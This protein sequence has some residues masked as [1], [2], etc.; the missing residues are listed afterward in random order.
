MQSHIRVAV[1]ML[2]GVAAFL[3]SPTPP[4]EADTVCFTPCTLFGSSVPTT[5]DAGPDSPVKV[6]TKFH[7]DTYGF[8]TGVRFYKSAAN[9]GTHVGQLWAYMDAGH[10]YLLDSV[11]FTGETASGWQTAQF[12]KPIA[13]KPNM[14]YLVSYTAPTGHFAFDNHYYDSVPT[15][16]PIQVESPGGLYT[17]TGGTPL[18]DPPIGPS[19][20]ANYYVDITFETHQNETSLFSMTTATPA[21]PSVVDNHYTQLGTRFIPDINTTVKGVRFYGTTQYPKPYWIYLWKSDGTLLASASDND[22]GNAYTGW[23]QLYFSTPIAVDAGTEYVVS[24]YQP[25]SVNGEYARTTNVFTA[26]LTFGQFHTPTNAGVFE[27]SAGGAP[28]V[29]PSTQTTSNFWVDPVFSLS[30]SATVGGVVDPSLTFTVGNRGT[31]CNGESNFSASAGGS[32]AVA[33]GTLGL[34]ANVSGA[35]ALSV[36]TNAAGGFSV[37]IRGVQSSQNMRSATHNWADVAGVYPAG[38]ALGAGE[39][40]GYTFF[41]STASSSV[42]NPSAANFIALDATNRAV[43]GSATS[44]TGSGCVSFDAQSTTSTPA[45][46]YS[47]SVIYTA[48]PSF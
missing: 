44:K 43:M 24:I 37:Y 19:T 6:A 33:F 7:V 26:P 10:R 27:Y 42:T 40:F 41:D 25:D 5:S 3:V 4:A 15:T 45:G 48:V 47:A 21:E 8:A 29:L 18:T 16:S 2:V 1:V 34:G 30:Q 23:M 35:Q 39:R 17:Y 46:S 36:V 28:A 38:A 22:L 20:N 12:A 9:T 11:T 32:A 13:L 14:S 31:A